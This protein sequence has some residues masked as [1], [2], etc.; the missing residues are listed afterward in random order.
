MTLAPDAAARWVPFDLTPGNQI[1]F[2]MALDGRP[3]TAILDTGVSYS[4]LAQRYAVT[5]RLAVRGEGRATA[6]GGSVP[7]G[8]V[9]T[10]RLAI[11]ALLRRGGSLA[12]AELPAAATGSAQAVDLLVGR[13]L[14]A[15]YAL[16]IDYQRHR[17]RL[18]KSGS[19]PFA[20]LAAPLSIARERMI[21]VSELRVAGQRIAPMVV[22]TGDG[23]A[24]TLG[25]AA[26][27]LARGAA[28][29]VTTTVSFGLAGPVVSDMAIVPHL[30]LG[31]VVAR[32]VEIR[33]EPPGGFSDTIG[34]AGRIGSGF[35]QR[36]RV[37]LD[38][39]A[40]HIL[41]GTTPAS[42]T[43]TARSTSGLLLGLAGD[44]LRVLH[45]MR[46]S[47][48]ATAGWR[49]GETICAVDGVRVSSGYARTPA[50]SWTTAP[51]GRVVALTDCDGRTRR[52]TL[53]GFY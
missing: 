18:L 37:L 47:P 3:V 16:D 15:G 23:S 51:A 24:I 12:V 20:G 28:G 31:E 26:W 1:R 19:R 38:P 8:R 39:G 17:F 45:V 50:A 7:V 13:D 21:Y 43:A 44:R 34:V 11:G 46:G 14:T 29:P 2:V 35:L 25:P 52:L 22:D 40:G 4:V 49:D 32:D 42:D 36:Y 6:I 10:A 9:A 30:S 27:A 41:L 53:N 5:H 33:A 48:A